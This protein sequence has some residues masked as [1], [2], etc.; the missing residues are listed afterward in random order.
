M[1]GRAPVGYVQ[2]AE[3]ACVAPHEHVIHC[4]VVRWASGS[5][6]TDMNIKVC[7]NHFLSFGFKP[8]EVLSVFSI[9]FYVVSLC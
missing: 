7:P 1:Q 2:W 5:I 8:L 6:Y 4:V 9:M 3:W